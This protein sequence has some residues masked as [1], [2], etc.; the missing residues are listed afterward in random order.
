LMPL[1][2]GAAVIP[3]F[4]YHGLVMTKM[5]TGLPASIIL[6][7]ALLVSFLTYCLLA[8]RG[9]AFCGVLSVILVATTALFNPLSTNLDHI[10]KSE[11]AQQIIK[12]NKQSSDRPLW[13]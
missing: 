8:G 6:V 9:A 7:V 1:I 10:Y 2:V 3:L 12:L 11:L 13:I 4:I 5:T